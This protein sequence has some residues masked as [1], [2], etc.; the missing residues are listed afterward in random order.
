MQLFR[1]G[2]HAVPFFWWG[3]IQMCSFSLFMDDCKKVSVVINNRG[4]Y[5]NITSKFE[6]NQ[7]KFE[8]KSIHQRKSVLKSYFG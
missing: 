1:V 3:G 4:S 5:A 8:S 2:I 7:K 6:E